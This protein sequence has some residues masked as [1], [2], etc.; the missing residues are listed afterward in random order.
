MGKHINASKVA[1]VCSQDGQVSAERENQ[2]SSVVTV[3]VRD[4]VYMEKRDGQ[5]GF[6]QFYSRDGG[7]V[8][9]RTR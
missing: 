3:S 5:E 1:K 2:I 6:I 9:E 8:P 7:P 4:A